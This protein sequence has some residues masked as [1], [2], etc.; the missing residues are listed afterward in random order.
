MSMGMTMDSKH[1]N[2]CS[3]GV[4]KV[5]TARTLRRTAEGG[6]R[7]LNGKHRKMNVGGRGERKEHPFRSALTLACSIVIVLDAKPSTP[8]CICLK[9]TADLGTAL[10]NCC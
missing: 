7:R 2:R 4:E 5:R 9:I 1:R 3:E 10:S 8:V 6:N